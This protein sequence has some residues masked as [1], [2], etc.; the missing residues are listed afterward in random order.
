MSRSKYRNAKDELPREVLE[1]L[2]ELGLDGVYLYVPSRKAH[3][4][5]QRYG[6]IAYLRYDEGLSIAQIADR[7]HMSQRRVKQI[8]QELRRRYPEMC[9]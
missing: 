3:K 6:Y 7:L 9:R 8:L 2:Y 1:K 5:D 4:R